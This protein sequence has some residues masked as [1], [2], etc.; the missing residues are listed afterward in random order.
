MKL[1][2]SFCVALRWIVELV[3]V[4]RSGEAMESVDSGAVDVVLD[5]I[6]FVKMVDTGGLGYL[7]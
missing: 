1:L 3:T 2:I 4:V 5:S 6:K 7:H